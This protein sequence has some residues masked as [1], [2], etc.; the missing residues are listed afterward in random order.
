MM[1]VSRESSWSV[2][3]GRGLRVKVNLLIFKDKKTKGAVT[4]N[5]WQWYIAIFCHFDWEDQHLLP[6]IFQSLKG[7]PGDL[8]R[9]LG[10]DT[11]LNDVLQMLDEH[12]G[13]LMMFHALSKELYSLEARI[14]GECGQIWG[15]PVTVG[16]EEGS[17]WSTQRKWSV[18]A[19]TR[20]LTPNTGKCWPH[21]VD[22][23]HPAGYSDLLLAALKLERW[24][25]ARDSLLPKTTAAGGSNVT[26]SQT[27]GNLFPS[28]KLKGNC[29]FTAWSATVENNKTEEDLG[30]KPVG[31]EEAKSS[32]GEDIDTSSTVGGAD[33]SVEYIVHFAN[34]VELYQN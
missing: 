13:V 7:F 30:V 31:E 2:L 3:A 32:A 12:Y 4:Y 34:M 11:T 8:A 15:A 9:S 29:T 20:T 33:Q 19:S 28:W 5:T 23:E 25:E 21:K 16:L 24:A 18:I 26:H 22:G 27:P 17:R 1:R 6:Y 14:R 10:E